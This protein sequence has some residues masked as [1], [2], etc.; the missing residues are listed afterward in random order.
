MTRA[1]LPG[2]IGKGGGAIV[3]TSSI[4]GVMGARNEGA[5]RHDE[6]RLPHVRAR[7]RG[8]V[9]ANR[10]IRCNAVSA[11]VSSAHRMVNANSPR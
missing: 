3:C 5:L 9:S 7:H 2:M 8:G 6:G 11:P 1:V 4:S 10:N